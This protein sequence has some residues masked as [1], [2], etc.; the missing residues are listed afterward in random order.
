MSARI[1]M[2]PEALQVDPDDVDELSPDCLD[3]R[4]CSCGECSECF[5]PPATG[6]GWCRGGYDWHDGPIR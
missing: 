1:S 5:I 3:E 2:L 4:P 6:P